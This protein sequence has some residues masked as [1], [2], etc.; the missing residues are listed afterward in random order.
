MIPGNDGISTGDP[1]RF[2]EE[3]L[4]ESAYVSFV[5]R[6]YDGKLIDPAS[7]WL[8]GEVKLPISFSEVNKIE[9][10]TTRFTI[11]PTFPGEIPPAEDDV[12]EVEFDRAGGAEDESV[13]REGTSRLQVKGWKPLVLSNVSPGEYWI[14]IYHPGSVLVPRKK[15]TVS[16]SRRSYGP[17]LQHGASLVVPVDWPELGAPE[18]LPP[19][20]ARNFV[21]FSRDLHESLRSV[22][23][24]KRKDGSVVEEFRWPTES[25]NRN[26]DDFIRQPVAALD[27]FPNAAVF[28]YLPLGEYVVE[29]SE[30]TIE[31]SGVNPGCVIKKS[32]VTVVIRE[33]SLNFVTSA[34]LRIFYNAED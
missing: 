15:V 32:S 27:R 16:S 14:R 5:P 12:Y 29:S 7:L 8:H 9:I 31:P 28:P 34:P 11:R 6:P 19:E 3:G 20:M 18:K 30:R 13:P 26:L 1:D 24:R 25:D 22:L 10:E 21:W 4:P 23:V 17:R 33:G 2:R